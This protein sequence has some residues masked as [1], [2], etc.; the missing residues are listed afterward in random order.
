MSNQSELPFVSTVQL[1]RVRSSL[2]KGFIVN[3]AKTATRE[4]VDQEIERLKKL[5]PSLQV[6]RI[7]FSV[8][9][10]TASVTVDESE[11]NSIQSLT[12]NDKIRFV[13][14]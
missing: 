5:T 2:E 13:G 10:K 12:G 9:S 3:F 11:A 7:N 1:G 14:E 4:D 6:N 8:V